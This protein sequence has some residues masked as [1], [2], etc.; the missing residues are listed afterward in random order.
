MVFRPAGLGPLSGGVAIR[1]SG[2][3]PKFRVPHGGAC[4]EKL[5]DRIAMGG[6]SFNLVFKVSIWDNQ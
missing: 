1:T 4:A 5:G 6:R 3:R 2:R